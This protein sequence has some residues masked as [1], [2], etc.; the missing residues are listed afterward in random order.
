MK[1]NVILTPRQ[2]KQIDF[3]LKQ[4]KQKRLVKS[5]IFNDR[6]STDTKIAMVRSILI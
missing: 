6:L 5:I 1:A 4:A 3:K 2:K